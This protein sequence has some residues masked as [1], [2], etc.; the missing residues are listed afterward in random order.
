MSAACIGKNYFLF[1]LSE[2]AK[3][4][5]CF[6]ADASSTVYQS[7]VLKFGFPTARKSSSSVKALLPL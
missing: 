2:I 4:T 7:V 1:L 6:A 3:S 5:V